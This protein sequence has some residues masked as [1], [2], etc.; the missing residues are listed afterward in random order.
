MVDRGGIEPRPKNVKFS[1]TSRSR[2][3]PPIERFFYALQPVGLSN[4]VRQICGQVLHSFAEF[5]NRV[6]ERSQ[7][8]AVIV[9]TL[10]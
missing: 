4:H 2:T 3:P 1:V 5:I 9:E 8:L 6:P 10:A 7:F